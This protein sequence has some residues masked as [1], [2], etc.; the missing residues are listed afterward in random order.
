MDIRKITAIFPTAGIMLSRHITPSFVL[1]QFLRFHGY[2]R[3]LIFY[4]SY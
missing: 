4:Y 1:L 3:L 2:L